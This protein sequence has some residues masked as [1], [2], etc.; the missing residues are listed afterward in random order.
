MNF[1]K[2]ARGRKRAF[3]GAPDQNSGSPLIGYRASVVLAAQEY[4]EPEAFKCETM[5]NRRLP[6]S[7]SCTRSSLTIR[8]ALHFE[9]E[10]V[11]IVK[12]HEWAS[13][14]HSMLNAISERGASNKIT[15][16][17]FIMSTHCRL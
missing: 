4:R 5:A 15:L 12:R 16:A 9:R 3:N 2:L 14:C 6:L 10:S 1:L 7:W 11:P 8:S 13:L 17:L